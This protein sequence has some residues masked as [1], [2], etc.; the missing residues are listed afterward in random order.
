MEHYLTI[1][2]IAAGILILSGW[3]E[4]IYQRIQN[5]KSQRC[6]KIFNDFHFSRS[7]FVA[8]LWIEL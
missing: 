4:Q 8:N 7:N 1:L 3:V 5:K 2:G 6:F